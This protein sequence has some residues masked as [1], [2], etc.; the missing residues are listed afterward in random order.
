MHKELIQLGENF[1]SR[2]KER[3]LSLKQVESATSIRMNY[4]EAIEEG[5]MANLI[6]PVYAQG[7]IKKYASFLDLDIDHLFQDHPSVLKLLVDKPM[8]SD[9]SFGISSL[10]VRGTPGNQIKWL[11]NFMWVA[12]SAVGMLG[13]WL[14]ARFFGIF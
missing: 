12:V 1:K 14:L 13:L 2:R 7:F 10:E 3:N 9:F 5:H 6:S 8:E 4:L 11:P